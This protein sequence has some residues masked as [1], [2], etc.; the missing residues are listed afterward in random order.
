MHSLNNYYCLYFLIIYNYLIPSLQNLT[1]VEFHVSNYVQLQ[2]N[3]EIILD[4][5]K[6]YL[7]RI[8]KNSCFYM[9]YSALNSISF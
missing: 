5:S 4:K 8:L 3:K 1:V 2:C 7:L 9:L 6:L